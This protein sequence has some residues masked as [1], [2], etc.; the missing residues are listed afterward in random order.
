MLNDNML[1]RDKARFEQPDKL[2]SQR[3]SNPHLAF[4]KG[5]HY[6]LIEPLKRLEGKIALRSLFQRVHDLSLGIDSS[7]LEWRD[8]PIFHSLVRLP[9]KWSTKGKG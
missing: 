9:V 2:N 3:Q 4:G 8:V 5:P 1:N 6:C 7:K